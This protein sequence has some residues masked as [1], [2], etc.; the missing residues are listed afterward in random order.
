[1]TQFPVEGWF[2]NIGH[3]VEQLLGRR[4]YYLHR[5]MGGRGWKVWA[6][7]FKDCMV[8]VEDDKMATWL[9]LKLDRR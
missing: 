8:E 9:C 6:T 7:S 3:Q 5:S 1:V 2:A 4:Q